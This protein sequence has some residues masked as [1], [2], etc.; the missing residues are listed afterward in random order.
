MKHTKIGSRCGG[1]PL[2]VVIVAPPWPRS[3][4]ALVIKNEIDYY[5]L[6]GF[7]TALVIVP[8]HRWFMS[9]NHIWEEIKA[10]FQ[11]LGASKLFIAP[12]DQRRYAFAKCATSIRH[13]F[14]GTAIDW[15]YAMARSARIREDLLGFLKSANVSLFHVNYI[16]TL[17]FAL[18]LRQKLVGRSSTVPIVL[19]THD[20]QAKLLTERQEQNPWTR[21]PDL[22]PRLLRSELALLKRPDALIH[23][24]VAEANFFEGKLPDRRHF[25]ALPAIDSERASSLQAAGSFV[26]PIDMLFIGQNHF[27]NLEAVQW[28]LEKVWPLLVKNR[29]NLK[30]VGPVDVLVRERLPHLF[31]AFQSCFAG[32]VDELA[33]YYN[34]ARCVI[35]PMVSGSG[36]SIKTIEALALGKPFVGTSK[37][38][39]GM[40]IE[41]IRAAGLQAYDDPKD[42]A[43]AVVGAIAD[44]RKSSAVSRS[45]YEKVFS[46]QSN[47]AARDQA[48]QSLKSLKIVG[49]GVGTS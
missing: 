18:R 45:V 39:R 11:E 6:R 29:Y 32:A 16:Q 10:G 9:Q 30:V 2:F 31:E 40:P 36:T 44:Q 28:F 19:E 46:M 3:G 15:E 20:I 48:L 7:K 1:S 38:F 17:G 33:P 42:F 13:G 22:L 26:P 49:R 41:K 8:F 27:P 24:S 4:A 35:A 5:N 25:L 14:R 34:S 21:K 23:L 12:L 43:V 47:F 37:A